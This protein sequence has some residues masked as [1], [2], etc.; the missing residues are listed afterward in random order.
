MIFLKSTHIQGPGWEVQKSIPGQHWYILNKPRTTG[1]G[2][3]NKFQNQRI[4]SFGYLKTHKELTV[5]MKETA[6]S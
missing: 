6:T 5:S 2:S 4:V 1:S 3:Q